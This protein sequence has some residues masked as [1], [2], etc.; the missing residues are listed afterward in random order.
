MGWR[1]LK[2]KKKYKNVRT[3]YGRYLRKKKYVPSGCWRD[4]VPSPSEFSNLDWLSNPKP[5]TSWDSSSSS[6]AQNRKNKKITSQKTRS[7]I[8]VR[9]FV[10]EY[11]AKTLLSDPGTSLTTAGQSA[12]LSVV[13]LVSKFL[14]TTGI[15]TIGT[16]IWK[17]G[18]RGLTDD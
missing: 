13:P 2:Q 12:I 3:A 14:E 4:A 11:C 15:G 10:S 5:V 1:R 17:P 7:A 18:F 8:D 6:T 9:Y 16:I